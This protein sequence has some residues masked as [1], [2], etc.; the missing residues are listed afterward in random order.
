M[1]CSCRASSDEAFIS[2]ACSTRFL[3]NSSIAAG[4][5]NPLSSAKVLRN[6][7]RFAASRP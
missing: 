5:L 1:R 4:I 6:N 3:E 2:R 7:F